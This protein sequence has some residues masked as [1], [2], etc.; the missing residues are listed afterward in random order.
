MTIH[1]VLGFHETLDERELR[2]IFGTRSKKAVPDYTIENVKRSLLNGNDI[3][4]FNLNDQTERFLLRNHGDTLLSE[5]FQ[6]ITHQE[7][8]TVNEIFDDRE[9]FFRGNSLRNNETKIAIVGCEND[10][11][12]LITTPDGSH[13]LIHPIPKGKKGMHVIQKRSL[14]L[15]QLEQICPFNRLD[16]PHPEDLNIECHFGGNASRLAVTKIEELTIELAVFADDAMW[17]HFQKLYGQRAKREMQR[18]IMAAV[19]NI[20][21]LYDQRSLQPRINIRVVRYEVMER[22]PAIMSK[23]VHQVGDV[24]K[25]LEAFCTYQNL[26]NPPDDRDPRHWDHA[27]LFSGY[28][29]Y[30]DGLRTVA[31]YAPVKGMCN[32][33]RSCTLNEGLDFGS[34][35]VVT[36][37]MGH[38]LGMYHDGDN[39]CDLR[40]CIMSPSIGAGKTD[41]SSCSNKEFNIFL[42]K[43][44]TKG[45]PPNCLLD[46]PRNSRETHSLTFSLRDYP[47]QQFTLDKQCSIFHGECW[48][49]ELKDGQIM[50]DVCEMIW[51]GNGEGIVRTAHPAM[52]GSYCGPRMWCMGGKCRPHRYLVDAIDGGWSEWN[53]NPRKGCSTG[54]STCEIDGQLSVSRSIRSCNSPSSNNGGDSCIGD[55]TK[56]IRCQEKKC[57]GLSITEFASKYCKVLRDDVNVPNLQLS[58][59]GLQY[60]QAKCK[61]WCHIVDS[62]QIRTVTNFPDGTPCGDGE[63]CVKGSCRPLVCNGS[64]VGSLE[65]EC[66]IKINIQLNNSIS[67][68]A[69]KPI[70]RSNHQA[71]SLIDRE[72]KVLYKWSEWSLW[73]ACYGISCG[74]TGFQLRSRKCLSGHCSGYTKQKQ[75]CKFLCGKATKKTMEMTLE[76]RQTT[77]PRI[78]FIA[79]KAIHPENFWPR[80]KY[81]QKLSD[82]KKR[83]VLNNEYEKNS[84]ITDKDQQKMLLE[85][86]G[87]TAEQIDATADQNSIIEPRLFKKQEPSGSFARYV[88][89]IPYQDQT[90]QATQNLYNYQSWSLWSD[91]SLCSQ[92][93]LSGSRMR[94]CPSDR[95]L[96]SN[97]F[98]IRVMGLRRICLFLFCF[99]PLIYFFLA[100]S[101][102]KETAN[103]QITSKHSPE[104]NIFSLRL[105]QNFT[106]KNGP[107]SYLQIVENPA[108]RFNMRNN[109]VIVVLHIQK[110]AGTSFEKFLVR[111]LDTPYPC[112]CSSARKRCICL[113]PNSEREMWLFSRYSTGWACGLHADF[114]EL[115]VSKCVDK[116]LDRKEGTHNKR[117]LFATTFLRDPVT[118]VI[119]EYRHVN[120]GA[121][122]LGSRHLCKGRAPTNDELPS[123]YDLDIGWEGVT[124]DEFLDCSSNLAF[125]RQTRMLADLTRVDCY[126]K[127]I[128]SIE[129]NRILL[130]SA[131]DNLRTMAYFGIKERMDDSQLLFHRLFGL[132][133]TKRLSSWTKS[134]SNN[135]EVST[136]QLE[137]IKKL[138][139]LD[140]ELY[141]YAIAIFE[142]RLTLVKQRYPE[143]ESFI[144]LNEVKKADLISFRRNVKMRKEFE[145]FHDEIKNE[146]DADTAREEDSDGDDD[147]NEPNDTENV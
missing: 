2:H 58:G 139:A 39:D 49:H 109:D 138:N 71:V 120:R 91:W 118:R 133:F 8:Y 52:E 10:I 137:R 82:T 26:I 72:S 31:G 68:V 77:T 104:H 144:V 46:N 136:A 12:G 19:N 132:K 56:G 107:V 5:D 40:C 105:D 14:S 101:E 38:S 147:Y 45:R 70:F 15:H 21:V 27:L 146:I 67:S 23:R 37:E 125:N 106:V 22:A 140:I 94:R 117:R 57:D 90:L 100:Y 63:Y 128:P 25:L 81:R 131:K 127:K 35:F 4:Q 64:I 129:R 53:D 112:D 99:P 111:Y 116:Q 43:L 108:N 114:T 20:D 65:D 130:E 36:H 92:P 123:C 89:T 44:G 59:I 73:T 98:P 142:E 62:D 66:P 54:C 42:S 121:T 50:E 9:C 3:L 61:I 110:T 113:R 97:D 69:L 141:E 78:D 84:E 103:N 29:L 30:R 47:G 95:S 17:R 1:F 18:F 93:C 119:S 145:D 102:T 48:K 88:S 76:N 143:P 80:K 51:C 32:G 79:P 55:D 33:Q 34:I 85:K 74:K 7:N 28:D 126:S 83:Y 11:R 16:D 115:F 41:W 122:W 13:F 6:F 24:D 124:L 60:Q 135:T 86:T 87:Y 96:H 75:S 134:K